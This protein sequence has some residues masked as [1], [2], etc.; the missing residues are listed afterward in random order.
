MHAS[1]SGL[2]DRCC[3]TGTHIHHKKTFITNNIE[4]EA[5]YPTVVEGA[6]STLNKSLHPSTISV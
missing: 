4:R 3:G 5:E 6:T 1:A 2:Y